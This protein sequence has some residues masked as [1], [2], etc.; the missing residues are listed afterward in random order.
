MGS[1]FERAT[2]CVV[3]ALFKHIPIEDFERAGA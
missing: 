3:F 1:G 2:A